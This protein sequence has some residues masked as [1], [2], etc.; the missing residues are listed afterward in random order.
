MK[1]KKNAVT[2]IELI[3][4]LLI[5]SIVVVSIMALMSYSAKNSA[6]GMSYQARVN[7]LAILL[8]RLDFDISAN[9]EAIISSIEPNIGAQMD[10]LNVFREPGKRIFSYEVSSDRKGVKRTVFD[11]N[12]TSNSSYVFCKDFEIEFF[13]TGLKMQSSRYEP[14]YGLAVKVKL[15]DKKNSKGD[16]EIERF[17][18]LT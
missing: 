2:I 5:T 6:S 3:V 17:F 14:Q 1:A 11:K 9:K 13:V 7:A 4:G 12:G 15:I 10:T 16:L 8:K 18:T